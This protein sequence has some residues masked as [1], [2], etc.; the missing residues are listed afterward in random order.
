MKRIRD[1]PDQLSFLPPLDSEI[2]AQVIDRALNFVE[3]QAVL[4][5]LLAG[6]SWGEAFG[7]YGGSSSPVRWDGTPKGIEIW[8]GSENARF[9]KPAQILER[10]KLYKEKPPF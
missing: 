5:A 1:N 7:S 2:D 10:A 4:R 9:I 3:G 8:P 6:K